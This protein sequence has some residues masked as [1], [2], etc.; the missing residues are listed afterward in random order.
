MQQFN[1]TTTESAPPAVYLQPM[2]QYSHRTDRG[3]TFSFEHFLEIQL[4]FVLN[5][6]GNLPRGVLWVAQSSN[7]KHLFSVRAA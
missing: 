2:N 1:V 5:L 6:E 4:K 7:M 3:N